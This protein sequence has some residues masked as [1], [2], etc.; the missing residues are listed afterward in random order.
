[1]KY[2]RVH[3]RARSTVGPSSFPQEVSD[4]GGPRLVSLAR[5]PPCNEKSGQGGLQCRN[6]PVSDGNAHQK[7]GYQ[8][9]DSGK[10]PTPKGRTTITGTVAEAVTNRGE[11]S[12]TGGAAHP[13]Q[14]EGSGCAWIEAY[15]ER[16]DG[17]ELREAFYERLE[18]AS[19]SS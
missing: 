16:L 4:R 9:G 15:L 10:M 7:E 18:L 17:K 14:A 2:M 5:S 6:A 12:R 1:M 8:K 13:T 11:H 3:H 19:R